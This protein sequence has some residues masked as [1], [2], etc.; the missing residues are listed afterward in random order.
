[1]L[2]DWRDAMDLIVDAIVGSNA[3]AY[4]A[5]VPTTSWMRLIIATD[6]CG[7]LSFYSILIFAP[8]LIG[9]NFAGACWGLASFWC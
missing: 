5:N 3:L 2:F 9:T 7:E 6:M 1:M 8:Y 4:H